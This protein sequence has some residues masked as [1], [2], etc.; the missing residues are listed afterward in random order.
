MLVSFA[1]VASSFV[2]LNSVWTNT[3]TNTRKD[4]PTMKLSLHSNDNTLQIRGKSRKLR[5]CEL[6]GL[7]SI[8]SVACTRIIGKGQM[9]VARMAPPV[10]R[11]GNEPKFKRLAA[12]CIHCALKN[13]SAVTISK[14]VA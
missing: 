10:F 12:I 4:Q 6:A 14:E 2:E 13:F 1:D 9:Y 11:R 5:L 3:K 8:R 7:Y